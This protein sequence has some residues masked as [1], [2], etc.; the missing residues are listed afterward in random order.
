VLAAFPGAH[1]VQ[2]A[3]GW[4]DRWREFHR[5]VVIGPLWVGPPWEPPPP[6]ALAVV[7]DPGRA[8]GTGAHPSTHLCLELLLDE[9]R[10]AVLDVGCGSGVLAIAAARLGFSPVLAVDVDEVAVQICGE[11]ARANGVELELHRLDARSS[12]LPAAALAVANISLE[13]IEAVASRLPAGRLIAA[14]YLAGNRPVLPGYRHLERRERRGWAADLFVRDGDASTASAAHGE[15]A[16]SAAS[17]LKTTSSRRSPSGPTGGSSLGST[18][19]REYPSRAGT[20]RLATFAGSMW[21]SIRSTRHYS[22]PTRV[23]APAA[24]VARSSRTRLARTQ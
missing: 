18:A 16:S 24:S 5:G 3:E 22:N 23:S 11:N 9:A 20:P 1:V 17:R 8:F 15:P 14:G 7:V 19:R 10:D 21:I 2:V 4:E 13:A 12:V 6:G